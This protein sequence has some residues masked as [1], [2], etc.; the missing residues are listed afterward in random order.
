[1]KRSPQ[2]AFEPEEVMAYLDGELEAREASA[3][4][5]HLEHCEECRAVA[6]HLRQVS[7]RMLDLQVEPCPATLS[8]SRLLST[9]AENAAKTGDGRRHRLAGFARKLVP[10]SPIGWAAVF[11][12]VAIVI[13]SATVVVSRLKTPLRETDYAT[14]LYS[15]PVYVSKPELTLPGSALPNRRAAGDG[16]GAQGVVGGVLGGTESG[17]SGRP[18]ANREVGSLLKLE[19]G[20]AGGGQGGGIQAPEVRGPMIVQ[21]ASI[22]ILAGNYEQASG[23]IQ[24]LTAARGG[25]VQDMT[26]ETRTGEARSVSATLRVPEK[27]LDEFV[28]DLRKLGHVE[29]E[30]RSNQEVTDQYI[31]LTARLKAARATEQRILQLLATRTGKLS[32]VLEA[33][34]ELE[35]VRGEI[36][37]MDGQRVRMEHEV[38]YATVKVQLNEEYRAQLNAGASSTG[39]QIRN[40]AVEG[41][42]NLEDGVVSLLLFVFA[43]GPSILFWLALLGTPAWFAWRHYRGPKA[44]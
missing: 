17:V 34:Q 23:A 33:E 6:A 44:D 5:G 14:G 7:E 28:G 39:R 37:S 9:S 42:R 24:P 13:I 4:A 38:S 1:M 11:G 19:P 20:V 3:L 18:L 41:F 26:A 16:S 36:E 8:S 27:R 30:T 43:Y 25:Y 15:S 12:T 10:Q 22:A 31:D 32:D 35:R 2:H 21:T 40:S 29:E